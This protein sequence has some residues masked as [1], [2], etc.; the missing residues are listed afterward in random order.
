MRRVL[1]A[2]VVLSLVFGASL[3]YLAGRSDVRQVA[4]SFLADQLDGPASGDGRAVRFVVRPGESASEIASSLEAAGLVR[5]AWSFRILARLR[6]GEGQLRA[7]EYVLRPNMTSGEI[8]EALRTGGEAGGFTIPEGWRAAEIADALGRRSLAKRDDFLA[9]VRA[10]DFGADF[11]GSRP[12]GASL[13]GYLFP[14]TYQILPGTPVRDVVQLMLDDF[15]RRVTPE[16]RARGAA[17]GLTLHQVVVLAS[18]VEREAV[19]A[20]ERSVI[21][22]VFLNRLQKGMRL[23]ADATVQYAAVGPD[24]AALPGGYWKHG[25][26]ELDL[27]ID[28]PYNTYRYAGLPPGPIANPGLASIRAVLEPTQTD[29]LYFVARPDGSHAFARTLKEHDE[30]VARYQR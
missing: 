15:G 20:D 30:N 4:A 14:D 23:Q 5:S 1:L 21:A 27:G 6:G 29:Y 13:E 19:V 22:A 11:L 24:P 25:L 26:S 3:A 8:L 16:M 17:R 7:G 10:G 12:P 9:V 28:S 2:V 18:I